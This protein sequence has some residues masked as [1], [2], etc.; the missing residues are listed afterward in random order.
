MEIK[1]EQENVLDITPSIK[2]DFLK[3]E[4]GPQG[5]SGPQGPKGNTGEKGEIGPKGE[6]GDVGESGVYFGESEPKNNNI[7][8]WLNPIG[9]P[10]KIG[11]DG[12][13]A[14]EIALEDGFVGTKQ[15]WLNSL[16]GETGAKGDKGDIGAQGPAGQDGHTPVKGVD[17]FTETDIAS[18]NIPTKTSDL[19]NDSGFT[20]TVKRNILTAV[21]SEDYNVTAPV[22]LNINKFQEYVKIGDGFLVENGLIKISDSTI[23]KIKVSVHITVEAVETQS[24]IGLY[25]MVGPSLSQYNCKSKP[26]NSGI[27]SLNLPEC[28]I[29]IEGSD[30]SGISIIYSGHIGDKVKAGAYGYISGSGDAGGYST[31]VTVEAIE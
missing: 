19:T 26:V 13:S 31:Y 5:P 16:K 15:E 7:N 27:V 29:D 9:K 11:L 2:S 23:K 3:G 17:Y 14:Y 6:K 22:G 30:T 18:L 1:L 10:E 24:E 4:Q 28:I 12:K 21:L 8:V 20:T 25:L